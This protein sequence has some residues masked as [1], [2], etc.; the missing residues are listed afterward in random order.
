MPKIDVRKVNVAKLSP[1][2]ARAVKL[3]EVAAAAASELNPPAGNE[4]QDE[5][6]AGEPKREDEWLEICLKQ[7]LG[8]CSHGVVQDQPLARTYGRLLAPVDLRYLTPATTVSVE[9]PDTTRTFRLIEVDGEPLSSSG[10]PL[11]AE[12]GGLTAKLDRL[13]VNGA[14]G[15]RAADQLWIVGWTL[16]FETEQLEW[17]T[18]STAENPSKGTTVSAG[19]GPAKGSSSVSRALFESNR[20]RTPRY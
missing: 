3:V 19:N 11:A 5:T 9:L 15:K 1:K 18:P 6:P 7:A 2:E 14:T 12:V 8:A 10:H 4:Q 20:S 16:Q 17:A 13:D